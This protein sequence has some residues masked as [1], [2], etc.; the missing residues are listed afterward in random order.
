MADSAEIAKLLWEHWVPPGTKEVIAT[1]VLDKQLGKSSFSSDHSA[2]ELARWLLIFLAGCHDVGKATPAFQSKKIQGQDVEGFHGRITDTG[3]ALPAHLH[4]PNQ[5][6]HS[7]ASF[8]I[9]ERLG[10]DRTLAIVPG[11]HHGVPPTIPTI[12]DV[13]SWFENTGFRDP[14]WVA[15]QEEAVAFAL[16]L[17]GLVDTSLADVSAVQLTQEAQ[18]LLT[19]L[20]IISD[21]LASDA[22]R[23]P[24]VSAWEQAAPSSER[25]AEAW[26]AIA[27]PSYWAA[28]TDWQTLSQTLY[29]ERFGIETPYPVQAAAI[30]L[31]N[32]LDKPGI[33]VIE[34]PM[35][36]GK[37]EAA[38]AAAEICAEKTGRGGIF[39]ALPTQ[40]TSDGIF[41]RIKD[42]V[43][44]LST[45]YGQVNSMFLAHGKARFNEDYQGIRLS[46]HIHVGSDDEN[47]TKNIGGVIA[48]D[49]MKGPKKG[50]LNSFVVGTIDQV[51]MGGL[52]QK[53]LALRH[54]GLANKVVIIDECH[55]YD[56][57][58]SQYLLKVLRWL[59][60][61]QVPVIVLSATLSAQSRKKIVDAYRG[62]D[63]TP[64]IEAIPAFGG[65]E[66]QTP[67]PSWVTTLEYP[68]ITYTTKDLNVLQCEPGRSGRSSTVTLDSLADEGIV[69]LLDDVLSEGGC[70]GVILNTVSR[71]QE[72]YSL[73]AEQ[74]GESI[75]RLLHSR[76]LSVDRAAKETELRDLLGAKG[77][78]PQKLIVVG[79]QVLEQSLD[80]DF[81]VMITDICPMDLL[82]QRLG[83]LHRHNRDK[84]PKKLREAKCF[85][86]GANDQAQF[87]K[88][89]EAVY[90]RYL[91]MNTQ[92]LLPQKIHLPSDI[93][94]LVQK[95]YNDKGVEV[96]PAL[97]TIYQE[98]KDKHGATIQKKEA[99][100]G[101]FQI[102]WPL[103]GAHPLVAWLDGSAGGE[104]EGEA[105]VRD[106]GD[107][108]E[109]VVIQQLRN[110][111]KRLLPWVEGGQMLA[112]PLEERLAKI[113]AG[114]TVNLPPRLCTPWA[115]D[116]VI[117]ELES[118]PWTQSVQDSYWL[119]GELILMLDEDCR[120]ELYGHTL[121]YDKRK[122]LSIEKET[123]KRDR[124]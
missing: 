113:A 91:L 89:A 47:D 120:A 63:S 96:P 80:I 27:L 35:G 13:N 43:D 55:A 109:V 87:D 92:A 64:L 57:Y 36:E 85:T 14:S 9:L 51:L 18:V 110:G 21:W 111:E 32:A 107:S 8:A 49:W 83:R 10:F 123:E 40:A 69:P 34:A 78:R 26:S 73:L 82:I 19:A 98:A 106:S 16:E 50:I 115:I 1:G 62:I 70:I 119:K 90:G 37:T 29:Q 53:H 99:R 28:S 67:D 39:F 33:I 100:A 76:F 23:F 7:L 101:S 17:A 11:G 38:L 48:S 54:L 46:A 56:A 22:K 75:V 108:L 12:L 121:R 30:E 65:C 84:R 95:A 20:V 60:A 124:E 2:L 45:G 66:Q 114:C 44:C 59:G 117:F 72:F 116:K 71:A 52:K 15:V 77:E 58:M 4:S 68:L 93:A 24:L 81:D 102:D 118:N 25:A 104:K 41:R 105:T 74:F 97:S 88:G 94:P 5:V 42:W 31:L 103:E 61:Y 79:T 3:L 112:K 86:L 122:G 6:P